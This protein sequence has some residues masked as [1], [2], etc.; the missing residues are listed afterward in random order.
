M[1]GLVTQK[2]TTEFQK[3]VAWS[4]LKPYAGQIVAIKGHHYEN[5]TFVKAVKED[6]II[7]E[8]EHAFTLENI[9]FAK[10]SSNSRM[11]SGGEGH[12]LNVLYRNIETGGEFT[13]AV[14]KETLRRWTLSLR[15]AS[16]EEVESIQKAIEAS[17][18]YFSTRFDPEA[19]REALENVEKK[20]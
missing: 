10:V 12:H 14:N 3:V 4:D 20:V 7:E 5:R 9:V 16:T 18:A 11:Y 6:G 15:K 2:S 1:A 19:R 13:N 8:G 17:I